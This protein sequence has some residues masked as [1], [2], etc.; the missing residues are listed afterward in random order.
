LYPAF[1]GPDGG[2]RDHS[3]IFRIH[4]YWWHRARH[5]L[6]FLWRVC[7]QIHHSPARIEFI[8]RVLLWDRLF[9]TLREAEDFALKCGIPDDHEKNLG[10][11]LLFRDA[12]LMRS[13]LAFRSALEMKNELAA[14]GLKVQTRRGE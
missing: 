5:D 6:N 2:P 7:H 3:F 1:C 8:N 10:R 4:T 13:R 9:E 14:F 11:M 12:Y